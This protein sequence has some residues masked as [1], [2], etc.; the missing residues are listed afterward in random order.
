MALTRIGVDYLIATGGLLRRAR[1]DLCVECAPG[2]SGEARDASR[3]GISR[4]LLTRPARPRPQRR[5]DGAVRRPAWPQCGARKNTH[6][7]L[8]FLVNFFSRRALLVARAAPDRMEFVY[9]SARK[10]ATEALAQVVDERRV[11]PAP[12]RF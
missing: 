10:Q 11:L 4:I 7:G 1:A 6:I 5:A 8:V 9:A 3:S 2:F 12:G